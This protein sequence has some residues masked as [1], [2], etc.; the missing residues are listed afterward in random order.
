MKNQIR[1]LSVIAALAAT[2]SMFAAKPISGPN[3]GRILTTSAPHAEFFVTADRIVTVAFYDEE[4]K[5]IPT[6]DREVNVIAQAETGRAK[7]E[8]TKSANSFTSTQS[9]PEGDGYTV[10]VQIREKTGARPT[11]HRVVFHDEICEEC[12]RAEYACICDEGDGHDH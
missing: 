11:N 7:L 9:L 12:S 10:V 3:G 5:P 8:F 1:L 2:V 6:G 4:L